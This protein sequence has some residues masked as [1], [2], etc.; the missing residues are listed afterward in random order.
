MVI[1][2]RALVPDFLALSVGGFVNLD[3][4]VILCDLVALCVQWG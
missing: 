1:K 2:S 3:N 4:N